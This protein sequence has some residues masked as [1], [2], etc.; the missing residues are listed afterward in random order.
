[1]ANGKVELRV[2]RMNKTVMDRR[3]SC[4]AVGDF[5]IGTCLPS[6]ALRILGR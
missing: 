2:S 5:G 3:I 4:R 1:M 6:P